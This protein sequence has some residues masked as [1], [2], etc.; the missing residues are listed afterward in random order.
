MAMTGWRLGYIAAPRE[1]QEP[2]NRLGFYMTAGSVSFV[3]YTGVN[4]FTDED[5]SI[6]RMRQE[7]EKRRNYFVAEINKLKHFS[8][9]MPEGAFYVFMNIQKTGM[10]SQEFCDYALD[11]HRLAMIPGNAFGASGEGFARLSYATSMEVLQE[12]IAKLQAIDAELA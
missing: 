9:R 3:Q 4:C 7:F 5:G 1:L 6:E 11:N 10:T 2:M 8:C 12:A